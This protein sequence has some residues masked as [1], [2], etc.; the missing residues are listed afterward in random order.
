MN[1]NELCPGRYLEAADLHGDTKVTMRAI[2]HGEVGE[3]KETRAILFFN[4]YTRG[5]VL[6]RTNVKSIIA[7]HGNETD[8][9]IGKQ[10]AIFPTETD[11]KGRMTP[12][13]RVKEAK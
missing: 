6:N 2:D 3:Q 4:E 11:F 5:M 7:L 1:A 13:I 9:W 8:N 12:C 10:I